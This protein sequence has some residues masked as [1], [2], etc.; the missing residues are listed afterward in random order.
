[1][2]HYFSLT[3]NPKT[4]PFRI[5]LW[6]S[7]EHFILLYCFFSDSN[8]SASSAE[9]NHRT[10][11][12]DALANVSKVFQT[13][14]NGYDLSTDQPNLLLDSSTQKIDRTETEVSNASEVTKPHVDETKEITTEIGKQQY[15]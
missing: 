13:P 15:F 12:P 4:T 7:Y 14:W 8:D 5:A 1:M 3:G 9:S 10:I 2:I 6:R 11:L